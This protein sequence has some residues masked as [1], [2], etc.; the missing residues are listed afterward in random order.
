M[1]GFMKAIGTSVSASWLV[2]VDGAEEPSSPPGA[3]ESGAARAC[4]FTAVASSALLSSGAP[5]G[6]AAPTMP[7]ALTAARGT[8]R[9]LRA[10]RGSAGGVDVLDFAGGGIIGGIPGGRRTCSGAAGCGV[11]VFLAR[12]GALVVDRLR[13]GDG[14]RLRVGGV[15]VPR[16]GGAGRPRVDAGGRALSPGFGRG[17]LRGGSARAEG[18]TGWELRLRALTRVDPRWP[19]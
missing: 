16:A 6:G 19:R 18:L 7:L 14:A 2:G 13:A 10:G 12:G 9:A 3:H 8:S 4:S 17:I 1:N 15:A 11:A 5:T